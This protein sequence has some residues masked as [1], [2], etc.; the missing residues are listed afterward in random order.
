M[1]KRRDGRDARRGRGTEM[2]NAQQGIG[3]QIARLGRSVGGLWERLMSA[4]EP[5]RRIS[6]PPLHVLTEMGVGPDD[7]GHAELMK[8]L[9]D[10][11]M[12]VLAARALVTEFKAKAV[13]ANNQ[14]DDFDFEEWAENLGVDLDAA[15]GNVLGT[16]L[17]PKADIEERT[18]IL[19]L[20]NELVRRGFLSLDDV[21]EMVFCAATDA[22]MKELLEDY[23]NARLAL[24][25]ITG[26][27]S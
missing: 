11:E 1:S 14:T 26:V 3:G 27:V 10:P 23:D 7:P 19:T 2:S 13:A 21:S 4:V 20:Q 12:A 8:R 6:P 16:P 5:H 25:G 18:R 17:N 9:S 22:A 15:D 24:C